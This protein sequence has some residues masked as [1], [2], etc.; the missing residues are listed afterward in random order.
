MFV[1]SFTS[2]FYIEKLIYTVFFI[3]KDYKV[4]IK[5]YFILDL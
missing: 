5:R 3:L 2:L 1:S 4:L